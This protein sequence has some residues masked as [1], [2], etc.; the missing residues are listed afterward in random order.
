ML[1]RVKK[2]HDTISI[3][4]HARPSNLSYQTF[5]TIH[6]ITRKCHNPLFYLVMYNSHIMMI[7]AT[8]LKQIALW[9]SVKA[10][11]EMNAR[12]TVSLSFGILNRC[13][14]VLNKGKRGRGERG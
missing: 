7:M 14:D 4:M 11:N 8:T 12:V 2:I 10:Y 6:L 9:I 1:L 3:S 5:I 13:N